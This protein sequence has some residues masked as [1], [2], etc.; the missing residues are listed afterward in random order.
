ML[1]N[2][3]VVSPDLLQFLIYIST[4]PYISNKVNH[5]FLPQVIRIRSSYPTKVVAVVHVD[6]FKLN[7]HAHTLITEVL[8]R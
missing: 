7:T 3:H 6:D 1:H 8:V 4:S 2:I 5:L